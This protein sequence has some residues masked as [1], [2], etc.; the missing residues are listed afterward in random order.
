MGINTLNELR[1]WAGPEW[2]G[3]SDESIMAMY[4]RVHK[5]DP[6]MVANTLGYDPGVGS[7]SRER[8][9][10]AIDN[11]QSNLYDTGRGLAKGLG[12]DKIAGWMDRQRADNKFQADVASSRSQA[13]G[14]IDRWNDV[15]HA[16]DFFNYAGGWG[17]EASPFLVLL[18][19]ILLSVKSA[20]NWLIHSINKLKIK[21]TMK[22]ETVANYSGPKGVGGWLFAM[23]I[24]LMYVGPLL[25]V[26]RTFAMFAQLER[27][28]ASN[29]AGFAT[30]QFFGWVVTITYASLIAR[31]GW[32][33][34]NQLVPETII[35]A[36]VLIWLAAVG[37]SVLLGLV[38]PAIWLG[39]DADLVVRGSISVAM[40]AIVA[41]V[42]TLYLSKSQRVKNT[43]GLAAPQSATNIPKEA[44]ATALPLQP[45]V[46]ISSPPANP[47]PI[48]QTNVSS[49]KPS[50][51]SEEEL[52]SVALS[53]FEGTNRRAGLW[54]KCFA[55]ADGNEATAT[56]NYLKA[57][58]FELKSDIQAQKVQKIIYQHSGLQSEHLAQVKADS[59]SE[60]ESVARDLTA[61][62]DIELIEKD[63]NHKRQGIRQMAQIL[64]ASRRLED[65]VTLAILLGYTVTD[66]NSGLVKA[67]CILLRTDLGQELTFANS[68]EFMEWLQIKHG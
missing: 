33:L 18:L 41:G 40:S 49:L 6:G 8:V 36:K 51:L 54:A 24:A 1:A 63:E 52:W 12:A 30:F 26:I 21:S 23:V 17:I 35:T 27:E 5:V 68:L 42:Y 61:A 7:L 28:G 15:H 57:R 65:A 10:S 46:A 67:P 20:R 13:L 11:Y 43:Y 58:F 2:A 19:I 22:T 56:A 25:S 48:P 66:S 47:T 9:S 60:E 14:G 45:S 37:G 55:M 44:Q 64:L 59:T 29:L 53:E 39:I 31:T 50:D 62:E 34:K 38:L 32:L 16:E 3:D 4:S